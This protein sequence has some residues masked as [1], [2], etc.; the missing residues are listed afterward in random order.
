MDVSIGGS[1]VGVSAAGHPS[2][3]VGGQ[4]ANRVMSECC[5]RKGEDEFCVGDHVERLG[6]V[7]R[8]GHRSVWWQLLVKAQGHFVC[9][10]E[11][12]GG[13]AVFGTEAVLCW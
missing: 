11:E 12:G 8:H 6:K 10:G 5:L 2:T 4:P 7:Y 9:E 3:Q 13:G 1:G